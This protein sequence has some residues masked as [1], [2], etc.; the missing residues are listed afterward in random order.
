MD[1]IQTAQKTIATGGQSGK[2]LRL[3]DLPDY[4]L[5]PDGDLDPF[6]ATDAEFFAFAAALVPITG[7]ELDK[8]TWEDRRDFLNWALDEG[9]LEIKDGRLIAV[10]ERIP[11]QT[12]LESGECLE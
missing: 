12:L 1:K 4:K 2:R 11:T 6:H 10:E 9:V 7:E 8:W 5:G 3:P